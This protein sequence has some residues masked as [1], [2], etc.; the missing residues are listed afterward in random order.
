MKKEKKKNNL[1][2]IPPRGRGR[3][4]ERDENGISFLSSS[5]GIL[6]RLGWKNSSPSAR[7]QGSLLRPLCGGGGSVFHVWR[8]FTTFDL[9]QTIGKGDSTH[10]VLKQSAEFRIIDTVK[11]W[12]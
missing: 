7:L 6:T 3:E 5:R 12:T 9:Q 1:S 10:T 4:R 8:S 11:L 2:F